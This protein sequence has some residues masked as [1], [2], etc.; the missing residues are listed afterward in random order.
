MGVVW[1]YPSHWVGMCVR[2]IVAIPLIPHYAYLENGMTQKLTTV[3]DYIASRTDS[4]RPRLED[5]RRQLK[6]A[7]PEAQETLK[8]GK[9][10]LVDDGILLV[11]A[12][13]KA[14][15][16]LHPTPSVIQA[17]LSDLQGYDVAENTIRF[18][19]DVAIPEGLIQKIVALRVYQKQ[20][21]GVGWK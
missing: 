11:Y 18:P 3:E 5:L 14:H 1:I 10:A 12:G 20:H 4:V 2:K 21:E 8:W 15:I 17:M 19:L 7:A 16:S 9:P 6:L 13:Y